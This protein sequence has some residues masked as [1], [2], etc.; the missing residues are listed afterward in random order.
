MKCTPRIRTADWNVF[1]QIVQITDSN[2]QPCNAHRI[3]WMRRAR[4]Q[5]TCNPVGAELAL[6]CRIS[7]ITPPC[8]MVNPFHIQFQ[9]RRP[10]RNRWPIDQLLK[11]AKERAKGNRRRLM[12]GSK[13]VFPLV[14]FSAGN[15]QCY[16]VGQEK[17]KKNPGTR[18][19]ACTR[20]SEAKEGIHS[21]TALPAKWSA[22]RLPSKRN[23]SCCDKFPD[24]L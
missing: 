13:E 22:T 21:L 23:A 2:S 18:P 6:N 14:R 24:V 16:D 7:K 10:C 3:I 17:P 1:T 15:L 9:R 19:A 4:I 20:K 11:R 8:S 12:G 5:P